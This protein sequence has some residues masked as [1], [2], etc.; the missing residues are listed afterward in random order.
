MST[1]TNP[2]RAACSLAKHLA[3]HLFTWLKGQPEV[4]SVQ[5]SMP[6]LTVALARRPRREGKITNSA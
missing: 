3:N 5:R 2:G 6:T 1:G 4:T